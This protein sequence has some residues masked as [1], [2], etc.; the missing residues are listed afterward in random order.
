LRL[1]PPGDVVVIGETNASRGGS[2]S[3]AVVE[4]ISEFKEFAR[5][6]YRMLRVEMKENLATWRRVAMLGG[7]ALVLLVTA[8]LLFSL[9]LAAVLAAAFYPSPYAWFFGFII[10]TVVWGV[11]AG[12]FGLLAKHEMKAQAIYPKQTVET[13]KEDQVWIQH[14]LGK[15]ANGNVEN[16]EDNS[17]RAA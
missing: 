17:S 13:L 8:W 2:V 3:A 14:E 15:N 5:T 11:G 9:A 10:M 7:V 4:M 12:I 16:V 1:P 6:R